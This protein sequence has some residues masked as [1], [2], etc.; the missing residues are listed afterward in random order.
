MHKT[1]I[2]CPV[3]N[4]AWILPRYLAHIDSMAMDK[5]QIHLAFVVNNSTDNTL[6]ILHAF[7]EKMGAFYDQIDIL[8][9]DFDY[10][11]TRDASRD[12]S[13]IAEVKNAFIDL[14]Q[15]DDKE[16][17]LIDSD[18]LVPGNT[19]LELLYDAKDVCAGLLPNGSFAGVQFYNIMRDRKGTYR[20]VMKFD[21]KVIYDAHG[22]AMDVVNASGLVKV[23]V[24]CG[25]VLYSKEVLDSGARFSFHRQGEDVA[26]CEAIRKNGFEIWCDTDVTPVHV[27]SEKKYYSRDVMFG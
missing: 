7:K 11:D 23:D 19:L 8:E 15:P 1:M 3:Q 5:S 25:C 9:Y 27:M 13:R 2:G 18:V 22:V 6:A 17:L 26:M 4:R 24:A 14:R 12:V 16:V 20:H 21:Q 10:E